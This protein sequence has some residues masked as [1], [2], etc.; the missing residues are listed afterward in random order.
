MP[1]LKM[2]DGQRDLIWQ[3]EVDSDLAAQARAAGSEVSD[4]PLEGVRLLSRFGSE[5]PED[6]R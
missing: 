3:C 4:Q 1:Y 6:L 5:W 2:Y